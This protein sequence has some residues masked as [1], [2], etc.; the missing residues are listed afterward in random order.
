MPAFRAARPIRSANRCPMRACSAPSCGRPSISAA[1]S[2][3]VDAAAN[4]FGGSQTA[5]RLVFT[6]RQIRRHRYLRHQQIRARSAQRFHELGADR[7]RH[8]RLRRRRLGLHLR[9]RGRMVSGRL[10]RARRPVR[11]VDR[12]QQR[13]TRP[14]TS[15]NSNG[16]ARSSAATSCW[17]SR[18]RSRS[19]DFSPAA[20]WAP[21]PTPSRLAQMTGGP[22]DIAAV[23]QY[24]SRGGVSL[25]LEQQITDDLGAVRPR[26][27]RRRQCRAL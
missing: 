20:A 9:R 21:S 6:D 1:T 25:N 23:R 13:R 14:D 7:H 17:G 27:L 4:Q 24:R 10:D 18:A 15:G 19:P 2:Q 5:N 16:S 11:S 26:R 8:V 3:K 12:A 22:A